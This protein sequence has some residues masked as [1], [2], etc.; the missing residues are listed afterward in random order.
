MQSG[1][2]DDLEGVNKWMKD[3]KLKLNVKK[4]QPIV[5]SKKRRA[6]EL[7]NVEVKLERQSL[8]RKDTVKYLGVWV[9]DKLTW[10]KHIEETG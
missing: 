5:L 6:C 8:T 2:T 10:Q 1:L 9:D 3:N 7:E 4:T